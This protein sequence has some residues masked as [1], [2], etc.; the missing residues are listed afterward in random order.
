MK[1]FLVVLALLSSAFL[2]RVEAAPISCAG[3]PGSIIDLTGDAV[4]M[5][6]PDIVCAGAQADGGNL[7]LRIGFGPGTFNPATTFAQFSLDTDQNIGTGAPGV[8]A[9]NNDSGLMGS[10]FIVNLGSAYNGALAQDSSAHAGSPNS[11]S[12][13]GSAAGTVLRRRNADLYSARTAWGR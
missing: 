1:M 11:F 10:D 13:V 6:A 3:L 5:G 12:P 4:G 7:V 8:D 2:G 9:G